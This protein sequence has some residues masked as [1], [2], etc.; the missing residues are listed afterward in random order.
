M[1]VTFLATCVAS[2]FLTAAVRA[3]ARRWGIV[4]L[5]DGKRKLHKNPVPLW[6]G[7]AVYLA[8]VLG[9]VVAAYSRFGAGP[10]QA[11][12]ATVLIVAAGIVCLFGSIDDCWCLSSHHKLLLQIAAVLPVV[13]LGFSVDRIVAFGY[14]VNL[15]WF[16][17]PLTIAWLV[18]CINALNLLDGM[19]GLASTVGLL[20]AAMLAIIATNMGNYHVAAM[21]VVLAGALAGFL[22]YNL[23]PATIFL[24]DSGSMVIGLVVGILGIQGA[25][26]TSATLAI[27]V[28]AVIMSLPMFDAG[29]ALVRRKLTGRQFDAADC[30]HIHHRLLERGLSTW[31][32]LSLIGALCLTTGAAATAATIFRNDAL[33]WITA[34][35]LMVLMIRMRLFGHHEL[36]LA[37]SAVAR[38]FVR[39]ADRLGKPRQPR[40][41]PDA[42]QLARLPFREAWAALVDEV[43]VWE[44]HRLELIVS[45]EGG[46]PRHY[47][48]VVPATETNNGCC[49]S[50][51]VAF[52][53]RD[54]QRCE[55]RATGPESLPADFLYSIGLTRVLELFGRHFAEHAEQI[56]LLT[57]T[58]EPTGS[59]WD[60]RHPPEA[61]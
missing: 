11:D 21:A 23:P 22:V 47:T 34:L 37:R 49:W 55:L 9:L 4:D 41:L 6:G 7:V 15:G 42:A 38:T 25:M 5:P 32:V 57:A 10:E 44:V 50:L 51:V 40:N 36:A 8:I 30:Q 54:G 19:D 53:P 35:A 56:P 61:A 28:P 31:Q 18:G 46:D 29:L 14:P 45:R 24:G 3:A 60:R 17:V 16:G 52:H 43:K 48:W 59:N 12:L 1:F 58:P 2:L 13:I 20:T 39:L 27:T 26:K 33:A